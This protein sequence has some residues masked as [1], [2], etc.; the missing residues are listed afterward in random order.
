MVELYSQAEIDILTDMARRISTYDYWIPAA[1]HQ[2]KIL[3]EMGMLREEIISHLKGLTGKSQK[4]LVTLMEEAAEVAL[5]SDDAVYKRNGLNPGPVRASKPIQKVLQSGYKKTQRLFDNLT[6]TTAKT[7]SKQFENILN[8]AY[9]QISLGGMDYDAAIRSAIKELSKHGVGAIEYPSGKIDSLET[10][11]R[12]ATITGVN[13][14]A[15]KMQEARADE[16]GCD[17][18]ETSAH[19]GARPS[20]A[21]WQGKVFSRSGKSKK[22]PDFVQ[23]TGYGKGE[24]LGG[25]NCSHSFSPYF[26]GSTRTYSKEQLEEYQEETFKYNG[27]KLT[28]YEA[29]QE[30]RNIERTIRRWK[31]EQTALR[32][33]GQPTE[34]ASSKIKSWQEKEKDFLSQTGLKKQTSRSQTGRHSRSEAQIT[35]AESEKYYK[36]WIGGISSE[37]N[38]KNLAAYYDMKYNNPIEYAQLRSYAKKVD[39][40]M[41]SSLCGF[42][43]FKKQYELIESQVVGTVTANGIRITKQS[44]HF[45]ERVIGTASDPSHS[46]VVR[47]GVSVEDVKDALING[48]TKAVKSTAD[49]K[50]RGTSASQTFYN[51]KCL[52]TVN[53]DTGVLIQCNP[54]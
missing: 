51:S 52:V 26:E 16:M 47:N 32:S 33:L 37:G 49:R 31:R 53:P 6:L 10:A 13:Q 44:D 19:A 38:P 48:K 46:G 11:V 4:E 9:M 36:A 21:E 39:S 43:N 29:L 41:I 20:H 2:A 14:T 12:R 40:G 45:I 15:L 34:E 27:Q 5:K 3:E 54:L 24:G 42:D 17:L 28:E 1:E 30:Q 23:S 25:W 7:A 35:I 18:V 8:Q 50:I 22:Y